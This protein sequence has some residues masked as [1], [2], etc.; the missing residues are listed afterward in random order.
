MHDRDGVY[1]VV[2][3]SPMLGDFS[4]IWSAFSFFFPK[5][6]TSERASI[7][8]LH[9][10]SFRYLVTTLTVFALCADPRPQL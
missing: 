10:L 4:L 8:D 9:G 1:D 7:H 6:I 3:Y 2:V 5:H